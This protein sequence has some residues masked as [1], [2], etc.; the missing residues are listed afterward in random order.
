[1][2]EDST[3]LLSTIYIYKLSP[4][5]HFFVVELLFKIS[6]NKQF[7]FSKHSVFYEGNGEILFWSISSLFA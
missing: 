7:F 6:K 4:L 1:M 5:S 3:I 2:D